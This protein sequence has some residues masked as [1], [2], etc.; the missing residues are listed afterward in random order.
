MELQGVPVDVKLTFACIPSVLKV[1]IVDLCADLG[2]ANAED[3][4]AVRKE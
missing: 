1:R 3:H 4:N 2:A